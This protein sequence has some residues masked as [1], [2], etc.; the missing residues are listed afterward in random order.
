[1]ANNSENIEEEKSVSIFLGIGIFL[2]PI[3]FSWFTL[4]KGHTKKAKIIS[5]AWLVIIIIMFSISDDNKNKISQSSQK[6]EIAS[7]EISKKEMYFDVIHRVNEAGLLSFKIQ[8][9]VPENTKIVISLESADGD[10]LGG[11]DGA[12]HN[13]LLLSENFSRR[14]K[15]HLAGKY[16][17]RIGE[18]TLYKGERLFEPFKY[19]FDLKT[20]SIIPQ[21]LTKKR[22]QYTLSK[23]KEIISH[24]KNKR[25][26]IQQVRE[27]QPLGRRGESGSIY[28]AKWNREIQKW[29][30]ETNKKYKEI[31]GEGISAPFCPRGA[32]YTRLSISNLKLLGIGY[33]FGEAAIQESNLSE[34]I[35]AAEKEISLCSKKIP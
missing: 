32:F 22:K 18:G 25:N 8:T 16:F 30:K 5:F 21:A 29:D 1:M 12:I 13:G 34:D 33:A 31:L 15:P 28:I 26:D 17:L 6:I 35:I 23:F 4:R 2:I 9:N 24:I 7:N 27:T 3:I 11:S 19:E 20:S 14:G 10:S